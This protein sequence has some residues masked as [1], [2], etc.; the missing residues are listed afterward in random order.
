M[1]ETTRQLILL[2]GVLTLL[3]ATLVTVNT[4]RNSESPEDT[5]SVNN[6]STVEEP[7][8]KNNSVEENMSKE[9][10][11]NSTEPKGI[12]GQSIKGFKLMWQDMQ[13]ATGALGGS[14][15]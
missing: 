12:I 7:V 9:S 13:T 10:S 8:E 4:A 2:V 11:G 1:K 3:T 5:D 6:N 15:P 14:E